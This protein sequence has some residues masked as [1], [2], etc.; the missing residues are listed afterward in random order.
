MIIV[1]VLISVSVMMS[2]VIQALQY[3]ITVDRF[4]ENCHNMYEQSNMA[5]VPCMWPGGPPDRPIFEIP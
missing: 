3:K 5:Y 1:L 4:D 2:L